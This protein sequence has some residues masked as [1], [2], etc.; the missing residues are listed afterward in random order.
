MA[1]D[2][3]VGDIGGLQPCRRAATRQVRVA[4]GDHADNLAGGLLVDQDGTRGFAQSVGAPAT[5]QPRADETNDTCRSLDR[6]TAMT[7]DRA[8]TLRP[9]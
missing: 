4:A 6:R 8:E 1:E 7:I 5:G 2:R 9:R 3:A